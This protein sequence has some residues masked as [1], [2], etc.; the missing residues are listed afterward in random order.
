MKLQK[1]LIYTA[2]LCALSGYVLAREANVLHYYGVTNEVDG[3]LLSN[4]QNILRFYPVHTMR[5][6]IDTVIVSVYYG[7]KDFSQQATKFDHGR[8]WQ[9][10]L[11]PINLGQSIQKIEVEARFQLD[12]ARISR[13]ES[14]Q[15]NLER[16]VKQGANRVSAQDNLALLAFHAKTKRYLFAD[17]D[18][19]SSMP[20]ALLN[21]FELNRLIR[22]VEEEITGGQLE[23]NLDDNNS[24]STDKIRKYLACYKV[25][26]Q[27][28]PEGYGVLKQDVIRYLKY[29]AKIDTIELTAA[30]DLKTIAQKVSESIKVQKARIDSN[31]A[32]M[33]DLAAY[34]YQSTNRS[35]YNESDP[36]TSFAER[37]QP[38]IFEYRL[39]QDAKNKDQY[40]QDRALLDSISFSRQ[41]E[42]LRLNDSLKQS[43]V[44][45]YE[46]L[47]TDTS[48]AGEG[49]RMSDLRLDIKARRA[50]LL[51]R[52]YKKGLRRMPA[53]DPAERIGIFRVRYVPFPV[54]TTTKETKVHR[55]AFS[56]EDAHAVF[57]IGLA[58]GDVYTANDLL[59]LPEFSF[60]RFGAAFALS[61]A[62][63]GDDAEIIAV[64]LTY[65]INSF[66]SIGGGVN[67]AN[68]LIRPY[69]SLGIN[70][71]AFEEVVRGVS[72]V[73][74]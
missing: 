43:I 28:R 53:L 46:I 56:G 40:S 70:K 9:I 29:F 31:R 55:V 72:K 71:V 35:L 44:R 6:G 15:D 26:A 39:Q 58:F 74:K 62:L 60:R 24:I 41:I 13:F 17:S 47:L 73:I 32:A 66:T 30:E 54:T 48:R 7:S 18:T 23:L 5:P 27:S 57:E 51:Y 1:L 63:F 42:L 11:P 69:Y 2:V 65:D 68:S 10:L 22:V 36:Q 20:K 34:Y 59:V 52:N 33:D 50:S 19:V 37:M 14:M 25:L 21:L 45:D 61:E 4:E 64:A 12:S 49:V 16:I 38:V 3:Q 8:Y 67:L